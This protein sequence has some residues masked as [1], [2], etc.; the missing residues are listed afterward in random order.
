MKEHSSPALTTAKKAG[1]I[2]QWLTDAKVQGAP[3]WYRWRTAEMEDLRGRRTAGLKN[4]QLYTDREIAEQFYFA[5]GCMI[6]GGLVVV[7]DPAAAIVAPSCV[8]RRTIW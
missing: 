8:A 4:P 5:Y 2:E 3:H 7:V 1:R 6:A